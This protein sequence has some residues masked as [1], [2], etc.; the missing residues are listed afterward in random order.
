[1]RVIPTASALKF[2]GA[3][4]WEALSGHP[5][6]TSVFTDVPSVAH[7]SVAKHAKLV[8]IAPATADLLA[9]CANGRAD[10]L[11]TSTLLMT[12]AP[13]VYAPAMHTEMWHHPATV[14]N[15]ET[16]RSRG[17]L[18]VEP[19]SGR[20]TGS[21]SG[22]GR[23]PEA[24]SIAA[25]CEAVM[26][27]ETPEQD[28][29]GLRVVITAG[30]T[31]EPLDPV[32]FLGNRSSGLQGWALANAAVARGAQVRII[33]SNVNLTD[34]AGAEVT[35]ASSARHLHREVVEAL[36]NCDVLIMAAAVADFRP[37]DPA[38]TKIKKVPG[39]E[40]LE[41]TLTKTV[42]ILSDIGHRDL[43]DRPYLV[44]FA[45]ETV[46]DL[47][48][49]E[50][51]SMGKLKNKGADLLIGNPVGPSEGFESPENQALIVDADGLV[52]QVPRM[53]KTSLSHAIFDVVAQR[54]RR[55]SAT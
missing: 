45:A 23:L 7:V 18:V 12:T 40:D 8:V 4:T 16:L 43:K 51:L 39:K 38:K 5:V 33:A 52:V 22:P 24:E 31:R 2:V 48:E 21:D 25:L 9:R 11:L 36:P 35:R 28:L 19:A 20:L 37:Q 6:S 50:A 53:S 42:D 29:A 49:L 1:M 55:G 17:A 47:A 44:G 46:A 34:P 14:A 3:P 41:L 30:G 13:V 26:L 32:R 10:D 27:R 54:V 15:I